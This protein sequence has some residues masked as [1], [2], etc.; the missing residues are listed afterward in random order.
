MSVWVKMNFKHN[1][2]FKS[3][4]LRKTHFPE[5]TELSFSID[6]VLIRK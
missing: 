2:K 1:I 3:L 6:Y 4:N 5:L